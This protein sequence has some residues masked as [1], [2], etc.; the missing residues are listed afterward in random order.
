MILVRTIAGTRVITTTDVEVCADGTTTTVVEVEVDATTIVDTVIM[1]GIEVDMDE[2]MIVVDVG[3]MIGG[4]E[5]GVA[6]ICVTR[7]GYVC[8]YLFCF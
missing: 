3:M 8:T 7:S 4:I 2:I 5:V 6:K 1:K